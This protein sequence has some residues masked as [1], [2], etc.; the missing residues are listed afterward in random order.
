MSDLHWSIWGF[1]QH[2]KGNPAEDFWSYGLDRLGRS[3]ARMSCTDFSRHV[4]M[5]R[6]GER[7]RAT[8][9]G[10]RVDQ[11]RR[12]PIRTVPENG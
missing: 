5:V 2:A 3:K 9:R 8:K 10:Y 7:P 11:E 12:K 1:V 6:D 4:G